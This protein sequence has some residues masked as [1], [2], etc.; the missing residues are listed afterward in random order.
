MNKLGHSLRRTPYKGIQYVGGRTAGRAGS[1]SSISANLTG[2]SGGIDTQPSPGDLVIITSVVGT[3]G[4]NPAQA[5]SGYTALGQLNA[6]TASYDA[7][8]DVSYKFMGSPPDTTFTL[9]STGGVDYAQRYT[10][11]VFRGVDPTTP[12]D[13]TAVSATESG[14]SNRPN[15]GSITPVTAGAWVLICGG[16]AA[17]TGASYTAPANFATDFLKGNTADSVDATVGSG[18]WQDWTS[19][20]VD[21]A[22]Y[23]GGSVNFSNSWAAYTL[24]LRPAT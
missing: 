12:M 19:G 20:A 8:L 13:A 7:C 14:V 10:V 6:S 3:F 9:P 5:I 2:L 4:I 18:Y 22:G 11:Q 21:P 17:L 24:A 1:T 15:P 16:G 23:T